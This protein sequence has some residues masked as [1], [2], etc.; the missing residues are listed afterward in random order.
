MAI[1]V[2]YWEVTEMEQRVLMDVGAG[3]A[4]ITA[5]SGVECA[6]RFPQNGRGAPTWLPKRGVNDSRLTIGTKR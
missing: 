2:H 1:M 5:S 4:V 6:K 3:P